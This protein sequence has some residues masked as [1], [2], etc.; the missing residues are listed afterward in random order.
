MLVNGQLIDGILELSF[1]A[2]SRAFDLGGDLEREVTLLIE[3]FD[4]A[5]DEDT[6][7]GGWIILFLDPIST[8]TGDHVLTRI[9][10]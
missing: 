4:F 3:D 6:S 1:Y 7:S 2:R 9:T 8:L 5:F 10:P